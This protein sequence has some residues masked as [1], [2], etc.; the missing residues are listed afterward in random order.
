MRPMQEDC[1][2][3]SAVMRFAT[4]M[5]TVAEGPD[6][7]AFGVLLTPQFQQKGRKRT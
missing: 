1:W 4:P 3:V 6:F 2:R 5:R 7:V